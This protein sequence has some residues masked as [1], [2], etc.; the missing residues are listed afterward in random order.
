MRETL[1]VY[2]DGACPL[3]RTEIGHYRG[4]SGADR[5][6]FIDLSSFEKDDTLG[7]GLNCAAAQARFHVRDTTGR[8]SSGAAAFAELWCTLPGWRWL[9]RA[10]S[11]RVFGFQPILPVAE[12][13]YR[14]F[15]PLRPRL[16]R[17][18]MRARRFR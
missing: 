4:C 5:V 11:L 9:G 3:C 16:A 10:V 17:L 14:I 13:A 6:R 15:L 7:P 18:L 1:T 8:L 12:V 2:Y